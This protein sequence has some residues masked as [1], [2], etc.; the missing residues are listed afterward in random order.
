MN[1]DCPILIFD[2]G[3]SHIRTGLA[4]QT[5]PDLS[6]PSAFPTGQHNYPIDKELPN[7]FDPSFAITDAEIDDKDRMTY[8]FA[9][10]FDHYFDESKPEPTNLRMVM[11]CAPRSIE[12]S[13]ELAQNAF[14]LL[15]ADAIIMKPPAVF[16]LT[17]F[18]IETCLCVDIGYDITNVVPVEHNM[19]CTKGINWTFNAGSALDLFTSRYQMGI[20]SITNWSQMEEARKLKE[21]N[22]QVSLN[23]ADAINNLSEEDGIL[24][25]GLTCGELLFRPK[26][27]EAGISK[28]GPA[29]TRISTLM[30]EPGLVKLIDESIKQCDLHNRGDLYNHIIITGGTSKTKGLKDRLLNDLNKI[31]GQYAIPNIFTPDDPINS[32]W[33]GAALICQCSSEN[34]QWLTKE[35]YDEDPN[36]AYHRFNQ[37][38]IR[39][40]DSD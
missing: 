7:D 12:C 18:S 24:E 23:Y 13:V 31:T 3:S 11:A 25:Y 5:L 17:T 16:S 29:D 36:L 40:L 1:T 33:T 27:Y 4:T 19:I 28:D 35:E 38:G 8:L 21:A 26:L 15:G 37:Y 32:A 22:I 20:D 14:E 39:A 6:I 34:E 30:E 10:I 9:S 2:F